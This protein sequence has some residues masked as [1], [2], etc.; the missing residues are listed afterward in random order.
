MT[1]IERILPKSFVYKHLYIKYTPKLTLR[2]EDWY[3][4]N[5]ME[6]IKIGERKYLISS[7]L[8]VFLCKQYKSYAI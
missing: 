5:L 2:L 1:F 6:V 4:K 3:E 8:L 7:L